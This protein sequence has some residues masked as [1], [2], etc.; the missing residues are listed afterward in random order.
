[1]YVIVYC[2]LPLISIGK[3]GI[4]EAATASSSQRSFSGFPA[5]PFVH[6]NS[7]LCSCSKGK[8][9]CHKSMFFTGCLSALRQPFFCQLTSHFFSIA[10][11][12]Y[13]E[14]ETIVTSHGL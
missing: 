5:W 2:S 7:M 1:M 11:T 4:C 6:R 9:L 8:S 10:S 13:F 12:T 3:F 14:L